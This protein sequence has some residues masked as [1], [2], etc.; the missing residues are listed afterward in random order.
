MLSMV[1]APR[2]VAPVSSKLQYVIDH[3]SNDV[4]VRVI[5]R[6]TDEVIRVL[7]PEELRM[8]GRGVIDEESSGLLVDKVI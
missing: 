4:T 3:E 6:V 8:L 7:P 2:A 1:E 5:N